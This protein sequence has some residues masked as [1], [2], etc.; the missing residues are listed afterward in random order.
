[1]NQC[2]CDVWQET[3]HR[4]DDVRLTKQIVQTQLQK[5][6]QKPRTYCLHLKFTEL[7]FF[8]SMQYTVQ[9][10]NHG[11]IMAARTILVNKNVKINK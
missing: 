4:S 7:I 2:H 5:K 9:L 11:I 3:K 10:T 6:T 8:R 1:M